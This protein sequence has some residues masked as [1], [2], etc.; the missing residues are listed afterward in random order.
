MSTGI[1]RDKRD[2][3]AALRLAKQD[4]SAH[5]CS[6]PDEWFTSPYDRACPGHKVQQARDRFGIVRV[7][8]LTSTC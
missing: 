4:N 5:W 3:T 6:D 8:M 7:A 2:M 1:K